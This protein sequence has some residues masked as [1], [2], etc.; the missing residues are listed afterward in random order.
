MLLIVLETVVVIVSPILIALQPQL[1]QPLFG[2]ALFVVQHLNH[3]EKNLFKP[4]K[5]PINIIKIEFIA[6][7][8]VIG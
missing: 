5:N 4:K 8:N 7:I 6:P 2:H 1:L 3:S